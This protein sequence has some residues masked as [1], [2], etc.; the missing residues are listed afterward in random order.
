MDESVR[1]ARYR[2][3]IRSVP[4][5]ILAVFDTDLRL[6]FADGSA[7]DE[8]APGLLPGSP[9]SDLVPPEQWRH[10]LPRVEQALAGEAVTLEFRDTPSRR[11]WSVELAPY[12]AEGD[13]LQGIVWVARDVSARRAAEEQLAHRALHDPLTGLANRQLFMDRLE[14]AL[15]RLSRRESYVAAIFIDLDRLKAINDSLGH[16]GGDAVLTEVARRIKHVLRPADTLARF[17]GDEFVALC[18]EVATPSEAERIARRL[19]AVLA[20]PLTVD[21]QEVVVTASMGIRLTNEPRT[22]PVA[23]VRE[24]DAAMYRAKDSGRA[25]FRF[26]EES[27]RLQAVDR[28][29]LE[30]DLRGAVAGGELVMLYQPQVRLGDHRTVGAEALLRW[31][32][33]D[34]GLIEPQDFIGIAEE[35]GL[36]VPMGHWIIDRVCHDA[37]QWPRQVSVAINLSA[38]QLADRELVQRTATVLTRT[39]IDPARLCLEVTENALF[40]EADRAAATLGELRALGCRLAIDDFGV[41]FSS[42]HHLR[43]LPEVDLLK[44]DRA[45]VSE[46]G[47]NDRDAAIVASVIL[48]TNSLGMEA[49]GEGIETAEQADHLRTMGCDYGQGY[50]FGMPDPADALVARLE[51]EPAGPAVD[52]PF[53]GIRRRVASPR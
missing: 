3:L 20:R 26:F 24:A 1:E 17:G 16:A 28:L 31:R 13:E 52:G 46:L 34:R 44:L 14:Q 6:A 10:I 33:P 21:G 49:L 53:A 48:L 19:G 32:H 23:L 12:R 8:D 36:M 7:I 51:R 5:T 27:M 25:T 47:Q 43:H 45:F 30:N 15:A 40:T 18:E 2:A 39:G 50:W 35:T 37:V 38:N 29:K 4:E 41:G 42:L 9:L 22:D 11:T